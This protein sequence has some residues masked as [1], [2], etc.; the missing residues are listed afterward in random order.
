ML[1][2]NWAKATEKLHLFLGKLLQRPDWL[3]W[4][5]FGALLGFYFSLMV[6]AGYSYDHLSAITLGLSAICYRLWL[7]R[8]RLRFQTSPLAWG[9]GILLLF[10]VS[11]KGLVMLELDTF[12]RILPAISAVGFALIASGFRGLKQYWLEGLILCLFLLTTMPGMIT[13]EIVQTNEISAIIS[14]SLLSNFGFEVIQQGVSVILPQGTVTV[15]GPCSPTIPIVRLLEM[16]VFFLAIYPTTWLQRFVLPLAA[17]AIAIGVNSI[18]IA[19]LA[20]V[21]AAEDT[22]GFAYWHSGMGANMFSIAN[23]IIFWLF[24]ELLTN[25]PQW[26]NQLG[27]EEE[28]ELEQP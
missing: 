24:W 20:L 27:I 28:D 16:T 10:W 6:K 25:L 12:L 21:N 3:L 22:Q 4:G 26:L 7:R 9:L 17:V 5:F 23:A 13:S 1:N 18:R 8:D 19:I 14:A 15:F 2:L 11:L